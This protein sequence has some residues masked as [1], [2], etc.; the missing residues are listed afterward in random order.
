MKHDIEDFEEELFGEVEDY[1]LHFPEKMLKKD[2][3]LQIGTLLAF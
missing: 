3:F 1:F 2:V